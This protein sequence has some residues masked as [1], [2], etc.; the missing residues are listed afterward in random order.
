MSSPEPDDPLPQSVQLAWGL[1]DT[2][3]RGPRRGLTLEQVLDAAIEVAGAEG[4]EALSMSRVAKQLGFTTMSLYRY[5]SNKNQ[6]VEL[7]WDRA[8]GSP[9]ELP[10]GGDWRE[11]LE[12]WA[13]AE[14]R[15]L[16]AH[17]WLTQYPIRTAPYYPNNLLWLDAGLGALSATP[18]DEPAKVQVVMMISLYAIG[19]ARFSWELGT[20][21]ADDPSD[22]PAMLRRIL[23]PEK[24]PS[25]LA[26]V[27]GGAFDPDGSDADD[28]A[29][30]HEQDFRFGLE[31]LLDGIDVLIRRAEDGS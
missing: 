23:D 28:E 27:E 21:V 16:R 12:A 19:R 24:Y 9:P 2:G 1:S 8:I 13:M 20:D 14:Y 7:A 18:L 15:S 29:V 10:V 22:T 25:V 17:K 4:L 5:V 26:A 3:T 30:W 31:R 6:L 11:R